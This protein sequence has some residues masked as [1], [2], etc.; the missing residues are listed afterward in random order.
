MNKMEV[1]YAAFDDLCTFGHGDRPFRRLAA[2]QN[3][4]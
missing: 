4:I 3:R 2:I 1:D